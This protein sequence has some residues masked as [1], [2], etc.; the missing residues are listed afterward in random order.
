MSNPTAAQESF[1]K[2]YSLNLL[3]AL[4]ELFNSGWFTLLNGCTVGV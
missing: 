1:F 3:I 2:K 4:P